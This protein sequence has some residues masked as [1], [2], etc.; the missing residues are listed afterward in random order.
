MHINPDAMNQLKQKIILASRSPRRQQLL[1]MMG[2]EFEVRTKETV[3]DY[4]EH[5]QNEQIVLYLASKKAIAF[6]N[7]IQENELLI[8]ADTI[9]VHQNKVLNKPADFNEAIEMLT[10]LKG[11]MHEVYT[12]VCI[13]SIHKKELLYDRSEVYF[14]NYTTEDMHYYISNFKPYD[15]A[16]SYG[17]QDWFGLT[18]IE[19]ING[20]FYNVMGLPTR[21]VYQQLINF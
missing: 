9:V 1:Q 3:E 12:G 7:E 13:A 10:T 14:R 8:S 17:I 11:N 15:K 4:P 5:L 6:E 20:C 2:I 19:K 18:C 21:K 16:G